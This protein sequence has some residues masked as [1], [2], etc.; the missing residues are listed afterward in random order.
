LYL[1]APISGYNEK[2]RR[3]MFE[4]KENELTKLGY[5]VLNPMKNGLEWSAPTEQH[6]K[7]DIIM[8]LQADGIYLMRGWNH[9]AGCLTELHVATACGMDVFFE[10]VSKVK[11]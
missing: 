5:S 1:S 7:R 6:M 4:G 11:L 8:L 9:S 3:E 2:E 10:G